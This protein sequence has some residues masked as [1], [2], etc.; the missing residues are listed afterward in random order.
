M[1]KRS[2]PSEWRV[3]VWSLILVLVSM[4]ILCVVFALRA[5]SNKS[6]QAIQIWY[7]ALGFLTAAAVVWLVDR[8]VAWL[9]D[10]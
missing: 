1:A 10:R 6:A 3:I 4:G 8:F 5:P 7:Y 9:M 2:T